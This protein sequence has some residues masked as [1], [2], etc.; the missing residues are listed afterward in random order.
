MYPF[1]MQERFR[2]SEQYQ[3]LFLLM[4]FNMLLDFLGLLRESHKLF[5][6]NGK[7]MSSLT[8]LIILVTSFLLVIHIYSLKPIITDITIK[9]NFLA[10]T[11]P[12]GAEFARLLTA[13]MYD[14]R[15]YLGL[16]WIFILGFSFTSFYF[17]TASILASAVSYCGNDLSIKEL[18]P[19]A[20]RSLKRPFVTWFYI[21]LLDLGY[22]SFLFAFVFPLVL[23]FNLKLTISAFT[24]V[25]SIL[26]LV[27]RTY[28]AVVWNL[29]LVVSILEEKC[30]IEA[31]GKAGQLIKG[32]KLRGFFLNLVIATASSVLFVLFRTV[33]KA[34]PIKALIIPLLLLNCIS[35]LITMVLLMASTVLYYESKAIH[36]EELELQGS[37]EYAKVS[38]ATPLI[39]ADAV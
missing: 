37:L 16:Q 9:A 10:A 38:S 1:A 39:N 24:I 6:R 5:F 29:A 15:V 21:T 25:A 27:V 12:T 3:S 23:I 26:A 11:S 32:S 14:F 13:M 7:A 30:G 34:M 2:S 31:L 17:A 20:L 35:C 18:L 28:L 4:K 22:L 36:G 19:R 33:A 8:L